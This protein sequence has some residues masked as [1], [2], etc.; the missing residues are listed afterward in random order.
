VTAERLV[1]WPGRIFAWIC[2]RY[3]RE[4]RLLFA[5]EMTTAFTTGCKRELSRGRVAAFLRFAL[6]NL[7]AALLSLPAEH[8]RAMSD[9]VGRRS[10]SIGR[11]A[12]S[13]SDPHAYGRDPA[14]RRMAH[15]LRYAARG[16]R[17]S[18]G[19]AA[20][21]VLTLGLGIGAN[22]AVFSV[23]HAVML[24]PLPFPES[25]R[26]V[27][28]NTTLREQVWWSASPLDIREWREQ[29]VA[30]EDIA[31]AQPDSGSLMSSDGPAQVSL[32]RV[33]GNFFSV[34]SSAAHRGRLLESRDDAPGAS[35]VVVLTFGYWEQQFGGDS[36]VVGQALNLD[37]APHTIVGILGPTFEAAFLPQAELYVSRRQAQSDLTSRGRI[38]R[39]V[40]RMRPGIGL[41]EAQAD[42]DRV[43]H[44]VATSDPTMNGWGARLVP[45]Q[46]Q[47]GGTVR[48][49]LLVLLGA[50]AFVLLIACANVAH[51]LLARG[52]ARRRDVAVRMALG[53]S[54]AR[55]AGSLLAEAAVLSIA[56]GLAGL[57]LADWTTKSQ[58]SQS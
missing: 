11:A 9:S 4:F 2:R 55:I 28:I 20:V 29:T 23:I 13:R 31:F 18:P 6:R 24:A 50:A 19:F 41:S 56:G 37:G 42:L 58:Y 10:H 49:A 27:A 47:L 5:E 35:P 3:P 22:T 38:L 54:R 1:R 8:L 36:R 48:P 30:L 40:A 52:T 25:D 32:S 16:L 33:S 45:L 34:L 43:T 17:K 7:L 46:E 12:L 26:L 51:L 57:A 14:W 15:D 53:A 39:P 44:S 21:A